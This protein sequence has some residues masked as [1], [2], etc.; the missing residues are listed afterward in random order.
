[1]AELLSIRIE[2]LVIQMGILFAH[3]EY[4]DLNPESLIELSVP[5]NPTLIQGGDST[6]CIC[7][8]RCRVKDLPGVH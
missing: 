3:L 4:V 1:M 8:T 7:K 6:E 5:M 2:V